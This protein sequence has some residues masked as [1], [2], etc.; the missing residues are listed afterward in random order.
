MP[1][2]SLGF[3][4]LWIW[5]FFFFFKGFRVQKLCT[6][7]KRWLIRQEHYL[8]YQK[9]LD[10][11]CVLEFCG[12]FDLLYGGYLVRKVCGIVKEKGLICGCKRRK[13]STSVQWGRR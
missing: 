4:E 6:V 12:S 2:V 1:V 13:T 9:I 7:L 11:S 5:D 10:N 3:G 8:D